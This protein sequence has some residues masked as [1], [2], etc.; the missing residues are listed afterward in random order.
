MSDLPSFDEIIASLASLG[1]GKPE[2]D[3][4]LS[5]PVDGQTDLLALLEDAS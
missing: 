5:E 3:P 2:R 4:D 1:S